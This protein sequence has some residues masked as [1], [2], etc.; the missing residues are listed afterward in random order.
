L[1]GRL[2]IVINLHPLKEEHLYRI[3]TESNKSPV[4]AIQQLLRSDKIEVDFTDEAL[5]AIARLAERYNEL[6]EDLGARRL[7]TILSIVLANSA[8]EVGVGSEWKKVTIDAERVGVEISKFYE[9]N[10][11]LYKINMNKYA[12]IAEWERFLRVD[13]SSPL[14]VERIKRIHRNEVKEFSN[15][16]YRALAV[17]IYSISQHGGANKDRLARDLFNSLYESDSELG[18]AVTF[19]RSQIM[20][21]V[22]RAVT[23]DKKLL[24]S[25]EDKKALESII[26]LV[27]EV[28]CKENDIFSE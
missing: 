26:H 4:L 9:T 23:S 6:D 10:Y 11:H 15:Q 14:H 12:T 27:G 2:P 1:R 16:A 19:V 17:C 21:F 24:V 25:D 28:W 18:N 5:H 13:P 8:Y 22:P 7:T 20:G 3:L